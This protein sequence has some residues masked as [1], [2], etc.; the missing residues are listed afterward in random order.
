MKPGTLLALLASLA[1]V[2][3][4]IVTVCLGDALDWS[5]TRS[6]FWLGLLE[7]AAV[8]CLLLAALYL[9]KK[10]WLRAGLAAIVVLVFSYL[11]A[12]FLACFAGV[13]YAVILWMTGYLLLHVVARR[14][15]DELPACLMMG[16]AGMIVLVCVCSLLK[17]GTSSDLRTVYKFLVPLEVVLCGK[18]LLLT[19][20]DFFT[21]K[22]REKRE[23]SLL[24][25]VLVSGIL[26][27]FLL[28]LGRAC[29]S[30]DY[31][32]LWY[33]LRSDVML[34][35]FTGI[36]DRVISTGS[37]YVYPK[38][39]ESLSLPFNLPST[40]CFVYAVNLM[41]AAFVLYLVW[42]IARIF[43]KKPNTALFVVLCCAVTPGIMNMAVTAKSDI[44]TLL[45]QLMLAYYALR[46]V[47]DG[48]GGALML[49][50]AA[51][52]FSFGFKP[53]SFVFTTALLV[54]VVVLAIRKR[55]ALPLRSLPVLLLPVAAVGLLYL[56]TYWLTGLP[57]T[58]FLTGLQQSLG[59]SYRFPY[60]GA[61]SR[62]ESMLG[63]LKDPEVLVSRLVR[64]V[65][66]LFCPVGRDLNH[67]IIAW[68][69]I[70]FTFGWFA[71][72]LLA[73]CRGKRTGKKL[74]EN[75]VYALMF[76][77]TAVV[78]V[79]SF[80]CVV[81]M[82]QADGN[83][84]MLMY[85]LTFLAAALELQDESGA[86]RKPYRTAAVPLLLCS[87]MLCL[88]TG[89]TWSDGL[90]PVNLERHGFY[91]HDGENRIYYESMG[92]EEIADKLAEEG[93]K[94]RVLA[95]SDEI[96]RILT[97][98]AIIDSWEDLS[99]WGNRS[100]AASAE[101]VCDYLTAA[102]VEYVLLERSYAAEEGIAQQVFVE[103]ADQDCF[104]F[105]MEEGDYLLLSFNP[106]NR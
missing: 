33:G 104:Q 62:T 37:V 85:T 70:L 77:M 38:A 91:H 65:K 100:L 96:P 81:Y 27:A 60:G 26:T 24:T 20:R 16:M 5:F 8:F 82:R 54:P 21:E 25:A 105:V 71:T 90:T 103:L 42:K 76:W 32:S 2:A 52:L 95:V 51:A 78:S 72:V 23:G 92:V 6:E 46:A 35:P 49:A 66:F 89:W 36:Y 3:W 58:S 97:L 98:P 34:A 9:P 19:T 11:H 61:G 45:V 14:W 47:Q 87:F 10:R 48:D 18:K 53:S 101:G 30:L 17:F 57:V 1:V 106:D 74:A 55:I 93:G 79:V 56:R 64:L 69:G 4:V 22:P 86:I 99:V 12:F 63:F 40:Y 43:C 13:A 29:I 7:L 84:F 94:C 39:I 67:V 15:K 59:F 50:L 75:P 28:Q 88:L 44:S 102:G 68:A 41:F 73:L 80:G 83:Y 31:D